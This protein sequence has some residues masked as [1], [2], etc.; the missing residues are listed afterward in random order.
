MMIVD[1]AKYLGF[2]LGVGGARKTFELC[3]EKYLS[4]C[5]DLS[6]NTASGLPTIIRYNQI[7]VPVFSYVSQVSVGS[8]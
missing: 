8:H 7:A 4:R 2:F 6:L 3:E 5:F 1:N